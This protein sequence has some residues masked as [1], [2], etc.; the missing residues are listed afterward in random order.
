MINNERQEKNIEILGAWKSNLYQKLEATVAGSVLDKKQ[1]PNAQ[2]PDT[3][4]EEVTHDHMVFY[5][6]SSQLRQN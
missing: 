5:H 1:L 6:F 3:V 2:V 4:R